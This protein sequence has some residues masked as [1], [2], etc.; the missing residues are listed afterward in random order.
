MGVGEKRREDLS[1]HFFFSKCFIGLLSW[2]GSD[3]P[4]GIL[5]FNCESAFMIKKI[6]KEY[7]ALK[8]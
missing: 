8:I 5:V 2:G 3:F 4:V 7:A 1:L 6:R